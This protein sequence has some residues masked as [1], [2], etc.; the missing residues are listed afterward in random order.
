[1]K[2]IH[3]LLIL[4]IAILGACKEDTLDRYPTDASVIESYYK[5]PNDATMAVNSAYNV[6]LRDDWWSLYVYSEIL[7]DNC[8]GGAGSGDGGGFQ[9][10]DRLLQWP[11]A[12]AFQIHWRTYYGGI[13]RT[14]IYLE[15]EG[16]INWTGKESLRNQY[17]AE[18]R[19]LR[20]YYHFYLARMF[21]NVPPLDHTLLPG[22]I[23]SRS[24]PE[25]LFG[26]IVDDLKYCIENGLST[27][28][29]QMTEA[30]WGR[31]TKW[32]AEAM[33]ARVFLYYTG[34]Y[35]K[36][37]INGINNNVVQTYL[38]DAIA[39]SGHGLVDNYA[40]LWRVSTY[41]ELKSIDLYAG[42]KNKEVVWSIRYNI[43]GAGGNSYGASLWQRMIG[44]RN[45]NV[46]PY[47]NG[48][49]AATVLPTTWNMYENGD[50]RK[51]ATILSWADEGLTYDYTGAQQA[52]Y[53]G[54]NL[55]KYDI[56]SVGKSPEDV[57]M[58]GSDW[59]T[60][61]FEDYMVIRYSD[62]LLMAAELHLLN[63]DATTALSYVNQVR[64][65]AFGNSDHNLS[66]IT[67]DAIYNER[68]LEFVGEGIRYYDILRYCKGDF[69]K[70]ANYLTYVD[71][72]DGG[73][74][75]RSI[76][77]ESLDVDGNSFAEKKGVF[78]L[79][80]AELNLMKGKVQQNEGYN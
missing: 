55:K 9:R 57:V 42:E 10:I 11:E 2:K 53:T 56:A 1:M 47:G 58:G 37:E 80:Q 32:A 74:N 50:T 27:P 4:A 70:L 17:K 36:T 64:A 66:S 38:D 76:D 25:A 12:D 18:V 62:I 60:E 61:A 14:N 19:F 69:S 22:E 23:P 35:N 28:Y 75:S 41:S 79:P 5:T 26:L 63:G 77:T 7:S 20:A 29:T 45:T 33:L 68:R 21:G 31:A 16:L 34:Y 49:G 43:T 44:P 30:N 67:L 48:W 3:I 40:S 6:L 72:T 78:Q 73:D 52:Q 51:T 46:D 59:Q 39:N 24:T 71:E 54:Y 13:Y 15:S 8:A 65:R